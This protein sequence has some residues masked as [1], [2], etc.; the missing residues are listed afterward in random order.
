MNY[1]L[2]ELIQQVTGEL[3]LL[4]SPSFVVGNTDPQVVQLLAL[5]NRLG[6]DI[7][8]QYEWPRCRGSRNMHCLLTGSDKYRR[9][10]GIER[11]D[12]RS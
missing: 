3:G 10:N 11:H 1:T 6:R 4:P 8:R 5:A 2:L 9:P 7:S 12:G